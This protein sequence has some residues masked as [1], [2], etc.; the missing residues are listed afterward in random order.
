M[1]YA[2]EAD[3]RLFVSLLRTLL[4]GVPTNAQLTLTLLRIAEAQK[5]PLPPPPTSLDG[6]TPRDPSADTDSEYEFDASSYAMDSDSDHESYT[7]KAVRE[8]SKEG[9][10]A[11]TN[12]KQKPGR[13][14]AG[15]LKRAAKAS[16]AGALSVDK[17][18]AAAGSEHARRRIGAV[19][20]PPL[21]DFPD[22]A[23]SDF[24]VT[25]GDTAED[26]EYRKESEMVSTLR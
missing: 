26:G 8:D 20:D 9:I 2:Q 12:P 13:R 22:T 11:T 16:V 19:S 18:K 3:D 24:G 15:F 1:S 25:L 23:S 21:T 5:A 10:D 4:I 7:S 6:P 17:L 14:V